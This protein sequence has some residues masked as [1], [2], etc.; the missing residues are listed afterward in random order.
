KENE[1]D[2]AEK[3]E[4]MSKPALQE[5]SKEVRGKITVG[6][7]VELD[8]EMMF[9]LLRLKKKLGENLSNKECLRRILLE[10]NRGFGW[11]GD[12][13]RSVKT[14]IQ[15]SAESQEEKQL[16]RSCTPVLNGMEH[17]ATM[18]LQQELEEGYSPASTTGCS[19]DLKQTQLVKK[20]HGQSQKVGAGLHPGSSK[21]LEPDTIALQQNEVSG[22]IPGEKYVQKSAEAQSR[23]E[24]QLERSCTPVLNVKKHSIPGEKVLNRLSRY[25]SVYR[26]REVGER[27]SYFGCPRPADVIHHP[28]RFSEHHSHEKLKPLCKQHHEFAHNGVSEVMRSVDYKYRKHRQVA[29]LY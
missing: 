12:K 4:N 5:Y 15:K 24:K 13:M 19:S 6:W 21:E 3:V 29:L 23:E 16:E 20:E 11:E 10:M 7:R 14:S 25:I 1:K 22:K 18:L 28:D 2:L 26:K 9:M 8:G 17:S 27:C